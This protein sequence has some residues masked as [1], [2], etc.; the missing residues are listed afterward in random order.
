MTDP[1]LDALRPVPAPATL[2]PT[3]LRR[4]GLAP[5]RYLVRPSPVGD[6]VVV[7]DRGAVSA[8]LVVADRAIED[9]VVE[10]A[11]RFGRTCLPDEDPDQALVARVDRVL[12]GEPC[13]ALHF[14]LSG[15]SAFQRAVLAKTAEIPL[16]EVRPYG[17]IAAE[18]G[19]PGAV[20]AVGT[21]LGRN[22]VPLLIPCHRVVRT[23]GRIGD[24]A[25]GTPAKRAVLRVEGV[26]PDELERLAA[27]GVRYV[28][29]EAA[30]T[31]CHP[32]CATARAG[33][34]DR[35]LP[36]RSAAA[37]LERGLRPCPRCRPAAGAAA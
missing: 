13:D 1:L 6:V 20:R 25:F 23:D 34:D 24:Y 8:C 31:F 9:V 11:R 16:G 14:D 22:P 5:D 28:G 18:I 21:A 19:R 4:V 27:R 3:V 15:V 35:R 2:L 37:A 12:A 26:D 10:F 29:D 17:W 33:G 7:H 32:T 30:G 36:L